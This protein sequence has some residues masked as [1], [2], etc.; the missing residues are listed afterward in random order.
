MKVIV[1]QC[2]VPIE[3]EWEP[4]FQAIEACH[5][6]VHAKG[7]PR[8]YT[9]VKINTRTDKEQTLENKVASVRALL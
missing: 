8:V 6:T 4:V 5:Q 2:V 7:F 1:D 3:G 9:T